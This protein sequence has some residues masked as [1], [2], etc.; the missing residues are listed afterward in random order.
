MD[1]AFCSTGKQGFNR[2][3]TTAEIVGQLWHANRTLIADGVP[4]PWVEA[5]DRRAAPMS[6]APS[7]GGARSALGGDPDDRRAAPRSSASSGGGARSALGGDPDDRR[8]APRSSAP[9]GG[10]ARSAL[11]GDHTH[12]RAPITNVVMMGM[13]EPLANL[14]C[15]V[16]ALRLFLD[17]NAYGLSRRR[18]TVSTSGLVP[19]MDR[20]AAE[21]PVALAV[22][23]HAPDDALRD[24]LVPVNRRHPLVDLLAACR[25]YLEVAPRDFVT[26]EYVMLDGVNDAPAQ[27]DAL[28]RLVRDV[29]CKFNLIPFNPFPG[30]AFAVSPRGRILAFQRRLMDAGIVTTIRK[31]RGEDI[32]AA[33]GQLAGRVKNR[34]TRPL[35]TRVVAA[36]PH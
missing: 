9:S 34:V 36:R 15:V 29:P 25:R 4:A 26:F 5:D 11:G 13:G 27:A 23:L 6:S 7:G 14:D 17:D 8:A 30:T 35:A 19:Q 18:V 20:L 32:D 33:C 10:G 28:V 2:N 1:C 22:S 16:P 3:L 24:R 12:T 31:T 21:C